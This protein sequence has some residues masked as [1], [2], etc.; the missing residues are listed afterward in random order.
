MLIPVLCV[1]PLSNVL[2]LMHICNMNPYP[3]YFSA[4]QFEQRRYA[5]T[6]ELEQNQIPF[7]KMG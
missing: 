1:V 6:K 3:D 7:T 5:Q 4:E 2:S